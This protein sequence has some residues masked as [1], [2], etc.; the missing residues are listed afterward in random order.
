MRD[1]GIPN[2]K[3]LVANRPDSYADDARSKDF[4]V[5]QDFTEAAKVADGMKPRLDERENRDAEAFAVL[6]LLIPDQVQP[7]VFNEKFAPNLKEGCT[8][9]VASGYNVFY[10]LLDLPAKSNVVMVAPR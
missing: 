5:T 1:S 6:F 9:V 2:D 8:V 3:I 7:R 4:T 10:K